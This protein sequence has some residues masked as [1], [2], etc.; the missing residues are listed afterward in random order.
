M[1]SNLD[2]NVYQRYMALPTPDKVMATYI[3]IDG[4]GEVWFIIFSLWDKII[5]EGR[6]VEMRII[7][8]CVVIIVV[9]I[10]SIS[11]ALVTWQFLLRAS[12]LGSCTCL[13]GGNGG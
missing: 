5:S 6:V 12:R 3:W 10:L 11:S 9:I 13:L 7:R 4:T 8:Q 1:A 2:A